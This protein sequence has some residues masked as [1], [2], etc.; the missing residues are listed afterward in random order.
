MPLFFEVYFESDGGVY[1]FFTFS[2]Y[3]A[4][5][6]EFFVTFRI[7]PVSLALFDFIKYLAL[8]NPSSVHLN[9]NTFANRFSGLLGS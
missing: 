5:S 7:F 2:L 8:S 4:P 1:P 3:S 9:I 6:M